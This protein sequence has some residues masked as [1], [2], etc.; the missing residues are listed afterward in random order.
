[1]V[2]AGFFDFAGCDAGGTVALFGD[3]GDVDLEEFVL[4][5]FEVLTL[6]SAYLGRRMTADPVS[7]MPAALSALVVFLVFCSLVSLIFPPFD[8]YLFIFIVSNHQRSGIDLAQVFE[9]DGDDD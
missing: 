1:M 2:R 7:V 4:V 6:L 3:F 5:V 8:L 9:S